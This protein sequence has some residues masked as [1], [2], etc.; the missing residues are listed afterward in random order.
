MAQP[1]ISDIRR[2]E[3][4]LGVRLFQRRRGLVADRR[5]AH[6][7]AERTL[8]RPRR[9]ASRWS[10]CASCARDGDLGTWGTARYYPGVD[11]GEFAQAPTCAC[12]SS[13]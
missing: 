6:L 11:R 12:A 5:A 3:A 8:D 7:P 9:R 13:A 1:S 2:L 4:E 10:P